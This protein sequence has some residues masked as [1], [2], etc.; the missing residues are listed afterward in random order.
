LSKLRTR[1]TYANVMSSL[2]V[3]LVLGGASAYA[4]NK[5]GSNQIKS[6][7]ITTGKI[8]KEA[9]SAAK[10]KK[11]AITTAKIKN[12]AVDGAK[13]KDGSLTG[14]EINASTLGTVPLASKS[15]KTEQIANIFF[16]ANEGDPKQ[17]I[18]NLSGLTVQATCPGGG[19]VELEATTA[20][21][22]SVIDVV[23]AQDND[24]SDNIDFNVGEV[25]DL[26]EGHSFGDTEMYTSQYTRPDGVNVVIVIHDIDGFDGPAFPGTPQQRDC[27]VGGLA[28]TS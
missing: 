21:S 18:L 23:T 24:Y 8:K 13:V 10:I 20:V 28:Y 4:A 26:D 25:F 14:T 12:G 7:A 2:A 15:G 16:T 11:N 27:M 3:F 5:I 6:N 9:V 22:H 1:I 19:E 17:T